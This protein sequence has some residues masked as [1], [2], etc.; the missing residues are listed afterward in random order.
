MDGFLDAFFLIPV[1]RTR[2]FLQKERTCLYPTVTDTVGSQTGIHHCQR[3]CRD[4]LP[5]VSPYNVQSRRRQDQLQE[6]GE[7]Q[8]RS[9]L[10]WQAP[11]IFNNR[12]SRNNLPGKQ[13]T[14]E[15]V[16]P[17]SG[18]RALPAIMPA[19]S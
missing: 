8:R 7:R 18:K 11:Y 14:L 19:L 15:P 6:R 17:S 2:Q 16:N 13:L 4:T 3:E 9:R 10:C 5:R 12:A 1:W